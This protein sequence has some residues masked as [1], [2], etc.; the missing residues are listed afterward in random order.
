MP[1][2]PFD[3]SLLIRI[4]SVFS[5]PHHL[6]FF[7]SFLS[8][9][10]RELLTRLSQQDQQITQ[11]QHYLTETRQTSKSSRAWKE[12][13]DDLKSKLEVRGKQLEKS[14]S[15]WSLNKL[16]LIIFHSCSAYSS[17]QL[18]TMKAFIDKYWNNSLQCYVFLH[19]QTSE[20]D[21][22]NCEN[23]VNLLNTRLTSQNQLMALQEQ[24][25]SKVSK[26]ECIM[27]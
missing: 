25:L 1:S 18:S 16:K 12:E 7:Y 9:F 8:V 20:K 23:S 6:L 22:K 5:I 3:H 26:R 4:F 2:F 17:G 14:V 27:N 15:C 19:L 24:E 21:K 11:L 13:V 10:C